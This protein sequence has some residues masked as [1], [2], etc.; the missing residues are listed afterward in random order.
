MAK[1]PP[2]KYG[3]YHRKRGN[4]RWIRLHPGIS[5][6]KDLM[7]R[8]YQNWL[9]EGFMVCSDEERIIRPIP[10]KKV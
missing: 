5:G 9:I 10:R 2:R 1:R 8:T 4:R 3:A 6:S 7:S